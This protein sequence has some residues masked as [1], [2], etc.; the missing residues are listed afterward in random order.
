MSNRV[1]LA[2][3]LGQQ[4]LP[5]PGRGDRQ[6]PVLSEHV[7]GAQSHAGRGQPACPIHCL[8]SVTPLCAKHLPEATR[9]VRH[10]LL[11]YRVRPRY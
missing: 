11:L 5:G 6:G 7:Q 9:G 10:G 8:N 3:R 2:V 4:G 1:F